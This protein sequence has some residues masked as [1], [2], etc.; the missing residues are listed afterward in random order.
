MLCGMQRVVVIGGPGAGKSVLAH[1]LAVAL[2]AACIELDALWWQQ[3]WRAQD[4]HEFAG[5]ID[6]RL[7]AAS[8]WVVDG[9]YFEEGGV[10]HVWPEADTLV[11]L[12]LPRRVGFRRAVSRSIRRVAFRRRLWNG[13]REPLRVL[14]PRSLTRLWLR[15]PAY[16]RRIDALVHDDAHHGGA[17]VRL[18]SV[19]EV[20]RWLAEVENG[21][22]T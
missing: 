22:R 14:T 1:R 17:L 11:W 7:A 3:D 13:N 18:R 6:E 4:P 9:N 12:D 10:E 20:R 5:L 15:W 21:L 19:R 16:N 2:E 8:R